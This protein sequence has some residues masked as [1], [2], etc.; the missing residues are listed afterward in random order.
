MVARA[1]ADPVVP[2]NIA[3]LEVRKRDLADLSI[4]ILRAETLMETKK[5]RRLP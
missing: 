4:E 2:S 3:V 5:C 1:V